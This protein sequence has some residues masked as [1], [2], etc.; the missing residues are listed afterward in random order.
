MRTR[1]QVIGVLVTIFAVALVVRVAAAAWWQ[2]RVPLGQKFV[3][4]DSESYWVLGQRIARGEPYEFAEARAFRTPG[5][6][7][8]LA[9]LF[10]I[11]GGDPPVLAARVWGAVLGTLAVVGVSLLAW[12]LFDENASLIAALLAALYPGAIAMSIFVLSE[13]L[14]APLMVA[15]LCLWAK[16]WRADDRRR[17]LLFAAT[18]GVIAGLA[19]LARPS[20]LLFSP[21][22]MAIG[23][24]FYSARARQ[25][26]IGGMMLLMLAVTMSPWWIRNAL[27]LN[28]FVPTSTE[29]GASLY[30]GLHAGATGASDMR[31]APKIK[32]EVI[33][34]RQSGELPS[35]VP[36]EVQLSDY[37]TRQALRWTKEHPSQVA[38]LAAIKF[39][40]MWNIWPN[41]P[42]FRGWPLRLLVAISYVP[43]LICGLLGTVKLA[44]RD[45]ACALCFLPG[46]YFSLI[47][48]VFVGSMRYREPAMLLLIVLAAGWLASRTTAF[49]GRRK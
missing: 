20:W 17:C 9:P 37:Y 12:K 16:A 33:A 21:I 7:A 31:F 6:P 35:N 34:K 25:L 36:L 29:A 38:R 11:F 30:D 43:I 48:M 41:E 10:W 23:L 44:R 15:H 13:A 42:S 4:A 3:F 18:A 28:T 47:H 49:L 32:A 5:Y 8:A 46:V 27:V 40:R 45:F 1:R 19:T 2:S 39:A 14:F 26:A 22:A 24:V